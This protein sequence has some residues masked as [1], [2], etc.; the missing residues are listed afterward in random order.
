MN[1]RLY[2]LAIVLLAVFSVVFISCGDDDLIDGVTTEYFDKN[3]MIIRT[4]D[5]S[6]KSE[7]EIWGNETAEFY[8]GNKLTKAPCSYMK[9]KWESSNTSVVATIS[10]TTGNS[11][12]LKAVGLG[13]ATITAT[14]EMGATRS[15]VVNVVV[16]QAMINSISSDMIFVEGGTFT[17]GATSE[18]GSYADD[19][20]M[21][22]HSVTLS[23]YYIGKYEITQKQWETVMCYNPSYFIG[24]NLPVE[25]VSWND[26]QTFITKLN[27]ITGKNFR[28]PTEAEWEYA[29][30]GGKK[31]KGYKY[32]GSNN[33]D[34]VAWYSDNSGSKT[35][36]VGTKQPNELGIYDMCGNMSEW[37]Q[38]WFGYYTSELQTNPT[39][40][41]SGSLRVRRGSSWNY[42]ARYSHVW[43]RGYSYPAYSNFYFG[44]RLALPK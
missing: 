8:I 27:Q 29:A 15:I 44:L 43:C 7:Y 38:D 22:A 14:D 19:C 11:T 34:A 41:T 24:D 40:P 1:K 9:T 2:L 20:D 42:D 16:N 13:S 36:E 30:R 26:C 23:D 18:Q 35:H 10:P 17:M 25:D 5:K 39:G 28:L 12:T 33:I 31:S 32:A 4:S 3:A 21:P 37:C 6:I